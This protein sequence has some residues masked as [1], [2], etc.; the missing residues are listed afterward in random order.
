MSVATRPTAPSPTASPLDHPYRISIDRYNR[1]IEAGA[2]TS[3][4]RIYLWEGQLVTKMTKGRPHVVAS[5][6][7]DQRLVAILP[8]GWHVEQEQPVE[9]GGHSVP[10]PDLM[11]VRGS[12]DDYRHRN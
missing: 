4:E 6:K 9:I 12:I 7:L 11:V 10:E 2:F 8:A 3:S 5:V 1:M